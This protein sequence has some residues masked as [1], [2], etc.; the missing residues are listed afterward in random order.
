MHPIPLSKT[1]LE[2]RTELFK[3][4]TK[5]IGRKTQF[6]AAECSTSVKVY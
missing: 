3:R 4:Q 5:A 6:W 2:F 1:I